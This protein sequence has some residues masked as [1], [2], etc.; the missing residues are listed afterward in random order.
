M[1][2][3]ICLLGVAMMLASLTMLAGDNNVFRHYGL[4]VGVGTTGVTADLGTMVTDNLGL[5]GGVDFMPELTYRVW[6]DMD[7][8]NQRIDDMADQY[9]VPQNIREQFGLPEKVQVEGKYNN[10]TGHALLDIHP[11]KSSAF[12]ITVGA[13][14]GEGGD[15]KLITAYNKEEGFLKNVADFNARRGIFALVPD[16][17]GQMAAKLGDY[18]LMPDDNGNANAYI[19][20]NNIRPYVGLGFGRAVPKSRVGF[21]FDLGAQFWGNPKV[22]NGVNGQQLTS[23]GAKG[24][25][26]GVLK[27]ISDISIF[28]VLS[29]RLTGRIF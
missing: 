2:K 28:P 23:E 1:K 26:G 29:F 11:I 16:A 27:V 3:K 10:F 20:V 5:R 17:Y 6:L 21:Q 9:G 19:K 25:D 13:Y 4:S 14:F 18:N 22:Y 15:S 7:F 24:E 12:R 8:I